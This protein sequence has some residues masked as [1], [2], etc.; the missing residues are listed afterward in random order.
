MASAWLFCSPLY[1][2]VTACLAMP[3]IGVTPRGLARAIGPA[4][5]SAA[6]MAVVVVALDRS[7]DWAGPGSRL[8]ALVATGAVSYAVVAAVVARERLNDVWGLAM[9]RGR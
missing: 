4:L 5:F 8:L 3:V 7:V 2:L 6:A 9:R 1:A